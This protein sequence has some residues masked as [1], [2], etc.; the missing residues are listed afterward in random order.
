MRRWG[1]IAGLAVCAVMVTGCGQEAEPDPTWA[2]VPAECREAMKSYPGFSKKTVVTK[3]DGDCESFEFRPESGPQKWHQYKEEMYLVNPDS[4]SQVEVEN[5]PEGEPVDEELKYDN[6]RDPKKGDMDLNEQPLLRSEDLGTRYLPLYRWGCQEP[7]NPEVDLTCNLT[8]EITTKTEQSKTVSEEL[9][10]T[11][12]VGDTSKGLGGGASGKLETSEKEVL[13]KWVTEKKTATVEHTPQ[14]EGTDH[15]WFIA[16]FQDYRTNLVRD[17]YQCKEYLKVVGDVPEITTYC[18]LIGIQY[19]TIDAVELL[20]VR[21]MTLASLQD[22]IKR[23]NP[24]IV[25][26]KEA[27][28]FFETLENVYHDDSPPIN[29][30]MEKHVP[31]QTN[32]KGPYYE[33]GVEQSVSTLSKSGL[34]LTL[35][36]GAENTL[37]LVASGGMSTI[38]ESTVSI[39]RVHVLEFEA[40]GPS[41]Y[42][43]DLSYRTTY[44]PTDEPAGS[45]YVPAD[46]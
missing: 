33:V 26:T 2:A 7:S 5:P 39:K 24:G 14:G 13:A 35:G 43:F 3:V 37:S 19:Q 38:A 31:L 8:L 27:E 23:K 28:T 21:L 29:P 12:G 6:W 36:A 22:M 40:E 9:G 46:D 11:L 18:Q 25:I 17:V 42:H 41:N 20:T 30:P 32:V 10:V 45:Y 16:Q 1:I 15:Q 4:P 34:T 44:L